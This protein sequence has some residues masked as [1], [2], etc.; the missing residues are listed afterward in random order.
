ME[1]AVFK[2]HCSWIANRFHTSVK[3]L[4]TDNGGEYVNDYIKEYVD[5]KGIEHTSTAPYQ[6]QSNGI[7]ERVNRT[8]MRKLRTM[9]RMSST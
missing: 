6:P 4:H 3:R 5:S 8:L 7:A 2:K 9:Q 1:L